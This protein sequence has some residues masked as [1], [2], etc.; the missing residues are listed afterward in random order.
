MSICYS[1]YSASYTFFHEHVTQPMTRMGVDEYEMYA[2]AALLFWDYGMFGILH[3][4]SNDHVVYCDRRH[5]YLSLLLQIY[6]VITIADHE[7]MPTEVRPTAESVRMEILK[8]LTFYYRY[9]K[10]W[11]T[12]PYLKMEQNRMH[13]VGIDTVRRGASRRGCWLTYF[14]WPD[15]TLRLPQL[16]LLLPALQ[17]L[18]TIFAANVF[19]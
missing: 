2:L 9:V 5:D 8:E 11:E 13:L 10:R 4:K 1:I 7:K 15:E 16:L 19:G 6:A 3:D 14:S 12:L 17:V 18:F